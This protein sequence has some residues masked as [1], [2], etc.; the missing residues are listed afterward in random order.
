MEKALDREVWGLILSLLLIIKSHNCS[1]LQPPPCNVI[2][3][4]LRDATGSNEIT[5][6]KAICQCKDFVIF[7]NLLPHCKDRGE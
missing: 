6:V 7:I 5:Y 3:T 2:H 1:E 4:L